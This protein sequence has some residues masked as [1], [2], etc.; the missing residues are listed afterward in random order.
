MSPVRDGI[1]KRGRT[2]SYVVRVKD[3]ETGESRPRWVGGFATEAQAKAARDEARVRARRGEYVDR[4]TVTVADYLEDWLRAHAVEVKPRT[5]ASYAY[6]IRQYIN[7]RIGARPIQAIRPATVSGLYRDLLDR[8]G[9]GGRPLSIRSVNYVHAVL[10]KAFN[11]AVNVERIINA[12]PIDQAKRPRGKTS[13]PVEVW[14]A[15]Q[16]RHFLQAIEGHRLFPF[17]RL[18]AYTGARRGELLHLRW[19]DVDVVTPELRIRG[20]AGVIAGEWVEGSTKGG[21]ERVVGLD[22]ETATILEAY[23][24]RQQLA[25]RALD[26]AWSAAWH[27]FTNERGECIHPDTVSQLMPKLVTQA[28]QSLTNLHLAVLPPARLHDLRHVHATLLLL[29]GVPVHVVA[30]RLGHADPS[31]TLRVYS[32]VLKEHAVGVADIFAN[33]V[34]NGTTA[35]TEPNQEEQS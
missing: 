18:A 20:S 16:L 25:A 33:A 34:S 29:A 12:N 28:N 23:R 5:R 27:V 3:P 11:D 2:W 6:L 31:I 24:E 19:T 26:A 21:R 15:E 35:D 13:G 10:R 22:Q 4:S 8:G 14:S 32:H 7:P 17:Y 30:D 9:R 1:T